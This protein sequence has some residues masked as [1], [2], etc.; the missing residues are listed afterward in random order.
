MASD[1]HQRDTAGDVTLGEVWRGLQDL[2][3]L[4]KE[5]FDAFQANVDTLVESRISGLKVRVDR[6]E[7]IVY[8]GFALW[9]PGLIAIVIRVWTE[10]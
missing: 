9:G 8:G 3:V 4:V 7:R 6:L 2:K 1:P 10:K 5:S